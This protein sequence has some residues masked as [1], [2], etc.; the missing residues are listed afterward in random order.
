MAQLTRQLISV[1]KILKHHRAIRPVCLNTS[2]KQLELEK[3]FEISPR[4]TNN[5]KSLKFL[6]IFLVLLALFF[7]SLFSSFSTISN[8]SSICPRDTFFVVVT[9]ERSRTLETQAVISEKFKFHLFYFLYVRQ[10]VDTEKRYVRDL[11]KWFHF[12]LFCRLIDTTHNER[13]RCGKVKF[14]TPTKR[15]SMTFER[16]ICWQWKEEN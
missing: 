8:L 15:L 3:F 10:K 11:K 16:Y 9:S 12:L 7:S 5:N 2:H 13:E 6:F 1:K 4:R 14:E